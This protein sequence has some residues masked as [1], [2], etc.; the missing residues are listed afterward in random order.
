MKLLAARTALL[1]TLTILLMLGLAAFMLQYFN[2]AASWIEHPSNRHFYADGRLR[3]LGMITDRSGRILLQ[4]SDGEIKYNEDTAIRTALMHITGDGEGN[5]ETAVSSAF[6]SDLMGWNWLNGAYCFNNERPAAGADLTL[7]LDAA[8]CATAYRELGSRRG[9]VGVYNYQTGEI[10]CM[11]SSPSFDP[12]FPPDLTQGTGDYEGVYL[13]RLFSAA[14]TPGSVFKLITAAAALDHLPDIERRQFHC[15]GEL[16]V[17]GNKV[18]CPAAHG[19]LTLEEALAHSCNTS[20]AQIALE[21]GAVRLQE[22]AEGAGF[23]SALLVDG[24]HTVPGRI[25]LAHAGKAE[26]AWAGI[27]Q[28]TDTANPLN[29]MSFVGAIG[30]K[31]LAV[32]P[33]IIARRGLFTSPSPGIKKRILPETTATTLSKMMR[34]NTVTVYGENNFKGLELCAKS[35]TAEVGEGK[36]PHAWFAGFLDREESPLAFVVIIEGGGSG[37]SA[38][39]AVAS[40]VLHS[41]AK[42]LEQEAA[43]ERNRR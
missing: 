42:E 2:S 21:I 30:N 19:E 11:A 37:S 15:N 14:Y 29:F 28:F 33:T 13:N 9:A 31:G 16:E 4:M 1:V 5:V 10:I 26:L 25:E 18:T 17:E 35:G 7:T 23:N 8:L 40:A 32:T 27:G 12:A 36:K 6:K 39:A 20:F 22:Y 34:H 24:I 38:A 3:T 41:T 43:V